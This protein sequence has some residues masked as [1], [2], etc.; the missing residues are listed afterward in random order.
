MAFHKKVIYQLY[1]KSFYDSDGDGVGDLRGIIEKIDYLKALHIDMIWFNPFFV[2]PQYDNGYDVADYRQID[3]RFGT[4]AD[5]EELAQKLKAAG[6]DIMLDMVLNHTSTQHVWFQKALAGDKH[7]QD[8]YYIRP[9]KPDGS[10]PTNWESKFGGLA[11]AP[12]GDTGNYY[13]HLYERRQADLDWHNPAVRQEAAAII[14]FWRAKGVHGFR[15]DVLNVIGKANQLVDAPPEVESKTLYTDTPIV[16]D[17]IKELA[18]NSFGQDLNSV[19]VGE[20]SSTTIK[21]SIAY[22]KPENHE[23]SMVFQFHHL[24]TDYKNGEK[25]SKMPYDFKALRNILHTWG[26]Q[27]DQGGGWQA[28]FWNNHDQPR[29]LNRFGDVGQYRVKSAEMLAAAIH[30]S[31]GTPYIYMGEEIGMTDPHYHSMADYVDVEAK[32]A[33]QALLKAGKSEKEAFAIILAKA[34]D[35]SRTPMQWDDTANAGFTTGTP[36]LRP[37]N[38]RE[39]NVKAELAHGEIFRF[40]QKLIALRKQYQVISNGSY[41][42][43]GTEIDRLYAYERV[44][45]DAHLLVLNNFS[46]KAITV[47]LPPR[48]QHARVLITNEADLTPTATMTL[49]PYATIALLQSDKGE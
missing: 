7:Y 42:P 35:N 37:T 15:F 4:M 18:A 49:P 44:A 3:P 36:W 2:S 13:L 32:N 10:L 25:W 22:T 1:P 8:Y 24:K 5:F 30:L 46:D 9:P 39:I 41:V 17:Y 14:N 20:M 28:L 29:A 48:F 40:Y 11:W 12:F 23:L 27:L 16:Q 43:F 38:Q 47:P 34:R 6:I 19:T 31:R 21:N 45:G 26:Q 33:Y